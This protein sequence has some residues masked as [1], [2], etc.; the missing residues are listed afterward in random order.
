MSVLQW[1]NILS[2]NAD[3]SQLVKLQNYIKNGLGKPVW[4]VNKV[5]DREAYKVKLV[6]SITRNN[7]FNVVYAK[8]LSK[9]DHI[10]KS[11]CIERIWRLPLLTSLPV[12]SSQPVKS[13][14]QLNI[15]VLG[16]DQE[17]VEALGS[18][19]QSDRRLEEVGNDDLQ[20]FLMTVF[21]EDGQL[22]MIHLYSL[23]ISIF[24]TR[25][26]LFT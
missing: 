10:F 9:I 22:F 13:E 7:A 19:W 2:V 23:N 12:V 26:C 8:L 3:F 15:G 6:N 11:I 5:I 17:I 14:F 24:S 16:L 4:L 18:T 25:L 21:L 20:I 1:S